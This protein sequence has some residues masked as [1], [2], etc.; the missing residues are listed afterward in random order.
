MG[1]TRNTG[2]LENLIAYDASDNVAI[3]TSVNP[4]YKVTLG[5]SLLGTSATFSS[6]VQVNSYQI[7]NGVAAGTSTYLQFNNNGSTIGYIG[8][9]AAITG[10]ASTSIAFANSS[11]LGLVINS[12]TGAATFSSTIDAGGDITVSKSGDSGINVNSTTTNG[13][14]VTRYKTTAAGNLWATGINITNSDSRW[15]VYNFG[16]TVSPFRLSNSTGAATFSSSVTASA[17][18]LFNAN[19]GTLTQNILT[20]K[21]G[22]GS[23]A[24]GFR[25]EA[26]NGESI[27]YTDNYTYN[28]IM[29]SASGKV[30]IGN[31]SP[32]ATLDVL[33]GTANTSGEAIFQLLVTGGN[34]TSTENLTAN[35]T[36]QTNDAMAADKGGSLAFGGRA[37]SS[38]TSGANWAGIAGLKTNGTSQDY[39]G[40]LQFWTRG[41][42]QS[43]KMRITSGGT[44]LVNATVQAGYGGTFPKLEVVQ[45]SISNTDGDGGTLSLYGNSSAA[46]D[47]GAALVLG[48]AYSGTTTATGARVRSGKENSTS[49]NFASYLA[50]DTRANGG[51]LT[52][53][54]RITSGGYTKHSNDGTYIGSTGTYHEFTGTTAAS[55]TLSLRHK[56]ASQPF[57][58]SITFSAATPNNLDQYFLYCQDSTNVKA[59][60]WSNGTFNSRTNTYTSVSDIN[61]KQDIIDASSQWN[62][63]KNLTVR[64]FRLKD[65]VA[66]D[67][68]YPYHIGVVAQELEL[69]SPN[70]VEDIPNYKF[71][72]G[73]KVVDGHIKTVKYSILYMKA[74][75]A[76]QEAMERIE[77]LE[78]KLN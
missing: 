22:G 34:R 77:K 43:E 13:V 23:G 54:M 27:F 58:Q 59:I 44:V 50:L 67:P 15:E 6:S 46:Q 61:L 2:Y 55:D 71:I 42:T 65:E 37:I 10:G 7:I 39:T 60:I 21:G 51:N 28:V 31:T 45:T 3:A 16:L 38:S 72:D 49:G 4:S 26:N 24:Y 17:G 56:A 20:V 53:R 66:A 69:I 47:T 64:K 57:G 35:L 52:E 40:Y 12:T 30:G 75:K 62:D 41:G 19:S 36:I 70:L 9:A 29:A 8:S 48:Q 25:V 1:A 11:G 76:L 33:S 68:N 5:G 63:I 18:S 14:A 73:E 78:A 32:R 74:I